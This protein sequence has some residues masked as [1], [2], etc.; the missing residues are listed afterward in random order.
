MDY[1]IALGVSYYLDGVVRWPLWVTYC[2][3]VTA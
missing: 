3:I 2:R 1:F